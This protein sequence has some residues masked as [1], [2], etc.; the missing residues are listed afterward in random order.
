MTETI[1]SFIV[2]VPVLS[3]L[4]ALVAPSV[5]TS[6]RFFT[7]AFAAANCLAPIDSRAETNA[8]RPVGIAEM[9]IAV[10]SSSRSC[11]GVPRIAPTMTMNATAVHA[12][13]P[14]TLVSESSS[15]CSG[16]RVRVTEVSIVAI[17]P[18]WVCIAV[19]VTTI[20]AVPRVTEVFW[21]SM[22]VRS[23]RATSVP[24][25]APALLATGALSPVSAASCVSRVADRMMR[26]SAGT[27]SPASRSTMSPGTR[28]TAGTS[29]TSRSRT[30]L[31]CGICIF[32]SASTLARAASSCRTPSTTLSTTSSATMIAVDTSPMIRLTT[33]T[34]ISMRFIGSRIWS[35]A[36]AHTDGGFSP[37]IRFCP[38]RDRRAAASDL[39]SPR[40]A[41]LSIAVTT[42]AASCANHG[43]ALS[44]E[45]GGRC[46]TVLAV[47]VIG[48][49]LFTRG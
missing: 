26:P 5:S 43:C 23:P 10:P 22:L 12:M 30:T 11:S 1:I 35:I 42:W 9:A 21:N 44:V 24:A 41:S 29:A 31:A 33:V 17:W 4:M 6:A 3:V 45:A 37:A 36:I 32:A 38:Y 49:P 40:S 46:S 14:R 18:I 48:R 47:S 2:S 27:R 19:A 28:S 7:M 20:A 16:D 39:L 8:G 34:A 15:F 25:S 13:I